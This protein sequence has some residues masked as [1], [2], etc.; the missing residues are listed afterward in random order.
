MSFMRHDGK[1]F[2]RLRV[3]AYHGKNK[4]NIAT[5]F[6]ECDCGGIVIVPSGSLVGEYTKSCGCYAKDNPSHLIHGDKGK[7]LYNIWKSMNERCNTKTCS[8]YKDYGKRGISVC[9]EWKDYRK[10]KEWSLSNGYKKTLTIDRI[11]NNGNYEPNN[12]RWTTRVQ[13]ARNKRNTVYVIYNGERITIADLAEKY[14]VPY[15]RVHQRLKRGLNPIPE[16]FDL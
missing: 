3:I 8:S 2:G 1:R 10:F 11:N 14:N 5:W 12:C 16:D 13:Q 15:K 9:Q 7:R 4:H 6:C